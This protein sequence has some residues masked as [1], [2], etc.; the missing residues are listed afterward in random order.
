M[1][2]I[3][4]LC[5]HHQLFVNWKRYSCK[6]N[7]VSTHTHT[8]LKYIISDVQNILICNVIETRHEKFD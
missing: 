4:L 7:C 2:Q 6:K 5:L 8:Y 1:N 3:N